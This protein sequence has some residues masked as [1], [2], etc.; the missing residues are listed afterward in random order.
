MYVCWAVN[1]TVQ[2]APFLGAYHAQ[3][4]RVPG[5]GNVTAY[6]INA[7]TVYFASDPGDLEKAA[8]GAEKA[9]WM[10]TCAGQADVDR[11]R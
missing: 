3:K 9:T 11:A 6:A 8:F 5:L 1:G 4:P 2:R 7:T 10:A